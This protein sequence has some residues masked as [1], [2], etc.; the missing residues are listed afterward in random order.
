[1]LSYI[2]M[3]DTTACIRLGAFLTLT[4]GS[5]RWHSFAM[6]KAKIC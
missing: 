6:G 4:A 2:G 5:V 1:M 3:D